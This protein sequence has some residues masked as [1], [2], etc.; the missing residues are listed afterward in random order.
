MPVVRHESGPL[1]PFLLG[2]LEA[3]TQTGGPIAKL[4]EV[5][6]PG[7]PLVFTLDGAWELEAPGT[8]APERLTSFVAGLHLA[9]ALVQ[10]T[11]RSWSCIELRLTPLAAHRILGLPMHELTNRTVALADLV[12]EARDLGDRLANAS[13]WAAR[14][15]L[16]ESFLLRRVA[17]SE[18]CGR[19]VEWSWLE[20]H[21]S[22]GRVAIGELANEL[23]WSHRR[24]IAR[25][26]EQVGLAPKAAARVLR[27][28]GAARAL[29]SPS[30]TIGEVA[31]ECGYFDQA[32]LNRDFREL[33]GI[34][35]R[36]FRDGALETGGLAA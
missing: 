21:R 25:F 20:L 24:L 3:W 34:T 32:H 28:D 8:K 6:F 27:F 12:P 7:V 22:A 36:A 35:P 30:R 15:E 23:G 4:R 19:E 1:R 11:D 14:F 9:P 13:S 10:P 33:A 31:F 29:R 18:I 16:V 5:P 17:A 26:R 2:P